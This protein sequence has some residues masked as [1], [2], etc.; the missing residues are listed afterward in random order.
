MLSKF[1]KII[2]LFKHQTLTINVVNLELFLVIGQTRNEKPAEDR[3]EQTKKIC[4]AP[5]PFTVT[6]Q[7]VKI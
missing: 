7:C 6:R 1:E 3:Q 2:Q 4:R 5:S